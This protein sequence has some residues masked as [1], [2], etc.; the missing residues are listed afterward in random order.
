M[1]LIPRLNHLNSEPFTKRPSAKSTL[2]AT[3]TVG[4]LAITYLIRH[5]LAKIEID[6]HPMQ[7][8]NGDLHVEN[9][10][11]AF[12]SPIVKWPPPKSGLESHPGGEWYGVQNKGHGAIK[13]RWIAD[14]SVAFV[15]VGDIFDRA[16]HSELAAEILR[17]LIVDA[18][19]RVFVLVGNHEQFMLEND[20]SNWAHN[21]V[22]SAYNNHVKPEKGARAHFRFYNP[23]I[24]QDEM[25]EEVF[26][27]TNHRYGRCS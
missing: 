23:A 15:Q 16:D 11:A 19:G 7:T 24:D 18:P 20:F 5:Q 9:L 4:H 13:A 1:L 17:Q 27:D 3:S 2:L 10:N 6:G 26:L 14:P 8:E 25:M 22:R 21:E 12:Q